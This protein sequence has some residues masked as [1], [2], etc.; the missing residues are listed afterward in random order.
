M[1]AAPIRFYN[2]YTGQYE[3]EVIYGERWLRMMYENPAGGFLLWLMVKRGFFSR[4]YGWQ[5]SK[6][7]SSG[8]VLPFIVKY[9]LNPD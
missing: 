7:L 1:P 4:Y 8:R 2:R 6:R 3:E 5:M 9:N